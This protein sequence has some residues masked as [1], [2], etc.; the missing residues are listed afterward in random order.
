MSINQPAIELM[1]IIILTVSAGELPVNDVAPSS[2]LRS[3]ELGVD[4]ILQAL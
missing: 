1:V 2:C 3:L 4:T